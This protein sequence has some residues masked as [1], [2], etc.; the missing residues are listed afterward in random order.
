MGGARTGHGINMV[1][2]GG[3]RERR[4]HKN[5]YC[6]GSRVVVTHWAAQERNVKPTCRRNEDLE[7][8]VSHRF[9]I[10]NENNEWSGKR[11]TNIGWHN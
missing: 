4:I 6:S 11:K 7:K 2:H 8:K 10:I 1:V 9:N 3:V 5:A